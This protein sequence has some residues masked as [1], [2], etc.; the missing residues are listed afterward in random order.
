MQG[1]TDQ[2]QQAVPA[3]VPSHRVFAF[4]HM[5]DARLTPDTHEGIMA[6]AASAPPIFYAPQYCG[7]WVVTGYQECVDLS[8]DSEHLSTRRYNLFGADEPLVVFPMMLDPPE[9]TRFRAPVMQAFS[10]RATQSL[11]EHVQREAQLLVNGIKSQGRCDFVHDVAEMYSMKLFMRMTGMPLNLF[12]DFR[13]W[14]IRFFRTADDSERHNIYNAVWQAM[15]DIIED[16]QQ[17]RK[18]DVISRL[19]DASIEGRQ[20]KKEELQRYCMQLFFGGLDTLVHALSHSFRRLAVEPE[21]QR[22]LAE[23]ASLTGRAVDE[24]LRLYGITTPLRIVVKD[25]NYQGIPFREG[26]MVMLHTPA[27]NRDARVY[28]EPGRFRWDRTLPHLTFN[29]GPH[30]CPG[31]HLSRLE[32][33]TMITAWLE[34][35]PEFELA[36]DEMPQMHAGL[37]Y[38]MDSLPLRW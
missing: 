20:P 1:V 3:H 2:Q 27:A 25:F 6:L 23:D 7:H 22:Q 11:E 4:D 35:I 17:Q 9:H 29:S 15:T 18:D 14:V 33:K 12:D 19:I 36:V 31:A 32:I 26:D 34:H 5:N 21:V 38:A 24:L 8:R 28:S 30:T 13:H 10:P 37:V 16:R